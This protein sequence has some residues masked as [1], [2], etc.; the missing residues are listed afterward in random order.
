MQG[1][2]SA[3]LKA[4]FLQVPGLVCEG[5]MAVGECAVGLVRIV[6]HSAESERFRGGRTLDFRPGPAEDGVV[7]GVFSQFGHR[8]GVLRAFGRCVDGVDP[9]FGAFMGV[10]VFRDVT[11][12]CCVGGFDLKPEEFLGAVGRIQD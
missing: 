3:C 6:L 4:G 11:A 7:L 10:Q 2:V 8:G 9:G 12:D 1:K 5:G